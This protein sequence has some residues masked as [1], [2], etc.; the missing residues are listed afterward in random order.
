MNVGQLRELLEGLPDEMPC[1]VF[2]KGAKASSNRPLNTVQTAPFAFL[3]C[4]KDGKV[5]AGIL[6]SD[7]DDSVF[8]KSPKPGVS[9]YERLPGGGLDYGG[10]HQIVVLN[11]EEADRGLRFSLVPGT[12]RSPEWRVV[13][14]R[15]VRRR[16]EAAD[17]GKTAKE[18][19]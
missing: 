2:H 10:K 6:L 17:D 8:S 1:Q 15:R 9:S 4:A 5:P 13:G 16:K 19:P 12:E 3:F 7:E 14:T 11:G 18:A